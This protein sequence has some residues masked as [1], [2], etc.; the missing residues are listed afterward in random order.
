MVSPSKERLRGKI[1]PRRPNRHFAKS[2]VFSRLSWKHLHHFHPVTMSTTDGKIPS[3]L[4]T[5]NCITANK[6]TPCVC[7]FVNTGSRR[8][9]ARYAVMCSITSSPAYI[10]KLCA[11]QAL[12]LKWLMLWL[13]DLCVT[14]TS[15]TRYDTVKRVNSNIH[16]ITKQM[17]TYVT[18]H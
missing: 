10:Q 17:C 11:P 14:V 2:A 1:F 13:S 15:S 3:V 8:T 7:I 12:L 18:Y 5:H 9:F 6:D 16:M 4:N